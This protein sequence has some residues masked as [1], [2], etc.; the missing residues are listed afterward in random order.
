MSVLVIADVVDDVVLPATFST[1]VAARQIASFTSA[2]VDLLLAGHQLYASIP[3]AASAGADKVLVADSEHLADR[4]AE[5]LAATILLLVQSGYTH[6]LFSTSNFGKN[7]APRVAA[8]LDV[9]QFSDVVA[10]RSESVY[11][12]PMYAGNVIATVEA[13]DRLK[14]ITVRSTAFQ[15]AT[16]EHAAVAVEQC[17][18]TQDLKR[19]EV[20]GRQ[21]AVSDRP[22]LAS[23][24][25]IVS[26]G[27]GLGSKENY[28]RILEPLADKLGAA[29]GASRAA[30]DAGFAP[31]E[32]QVGQTG[33]VVAPEIYVAVGLSGAI[34]HLAG[35]RDSR[36][37]VAINSDKDA[38]IFGVAN[39]GLVAD[40][41]DA[42]PEWLAATE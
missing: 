14:V 9:A 21:A 18:V 22:D 15:P 37:I 42:V 24:S 33:K 2:R 20:T 29:L 7:V 30:V 11:D 4:G 38:P 25:I 6:I 31:N 10:V 32:R 12:R 40:L 23:A 3:V 41:F 39:Y 5:N 27:R 28:E 17:V 19:S 8:K 26:G 36:I 34:Q 35:M 13:L 16:A 1:L